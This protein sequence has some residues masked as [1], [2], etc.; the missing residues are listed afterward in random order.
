MERERE[1]SSFEAKFKKMELKNNRDVK[2][3]KI[4]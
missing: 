1:I 4:A 3:L 2:E